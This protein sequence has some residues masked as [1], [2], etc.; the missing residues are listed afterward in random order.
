MSL[1]R[2]QQ[3]DRTAAT[4]T[5]VLDATVELL[6][7][8]G[9]AG[10]STRLAAE[11]AGVSLGA[12]QHH[13]RTK[14]ELSVEA[15]RFVTERL[16]EEFVAAAPESPDPVDRFG[17][18]LDRLF[19]VFKG[20]T[21]AA[22]VEI[23][24]ASR[25]DA[26]LQGPVRDLNQDVEEIILRSARELLPELVPLAEFN[27]VLQTS[28]SAVRGLAIATMDPIIEVDDQWILIRGQLLEIANK[29]VR[30]ESP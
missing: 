24:L 11:R 25:T 2:R 1:P 16:A 3:S 23:Q 26:E 20:P 5:S 29:L 30:Q 15:M 21:F 8:R 12:L 27:A 22:A 9:Y 6:I 7:E 17:A 14:A 10:T 18:I 13:F 28:V 19:V 4:R